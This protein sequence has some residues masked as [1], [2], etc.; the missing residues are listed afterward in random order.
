[1]TEAQKKSLEWFHELP[2]ECKPSG[3]TFN[4][5]PIGVC[6][7]EGLPIGNDIL[8]LA[9]VGSMTLWL[10][11]T[12]SSIRWWRIKKRAVHWHVATG[13]GSLI[14]ET[15]NIELIGTGHTP[16]QAMVMACRAVLRDESGKYTGKG[17]KETGEDKTC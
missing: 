7:S 15:L 16:F 5:E 9:C 10:H 12:M 11:A 17:P 2:E 6:S 3:L 8:E 1:M 4:R 13:V 14:D